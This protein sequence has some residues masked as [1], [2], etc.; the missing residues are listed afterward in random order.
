MY[1]SCNKR[2]VN[3]YFE[4][5]GSPRYMRVFYLRF[6]VYAIQKWPFSGTYPL[7]NSHPWSFYMRICYMG[8][9]FWSPFLSHITRSTCILFDI[10]HLGVCLCVSVCMLVCVCFSC[11]FPS[12]PLLSEVTVDFIQNTNDYRMFWRS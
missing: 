10:L 9:Y 5:T 3:L 11:L 12:F 7:I 8:V 6:R 1:R 4:C 2:C